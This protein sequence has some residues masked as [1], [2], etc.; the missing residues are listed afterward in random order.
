MEKKFNLVY[1]IW[2]GDD[3]VPNTKIIYGD[4]NNIKDPYYLFLHYVNDTT[5]QKGKF[6][7]IRHKLNQIS[8][9]DSEKYY[10]VINYGS[11]LIDL[12]YHENKDKRV[13]FDP[14][15]EEVKT[16]FRNNKNL[17]IIFINEHEP[18]D[19]EG[20]ELLHNY[21]KKN[22]LD[23]NRF[24]LI[25]NNSNL[26][27]HTKKFDSKINTYK[28]NFIPHS[29]T[30]VLLKI[31]GVDFIEEKL[32]KFFMCFNKSPKKHR[33]ALL[34][35]MT[36]NNLLNQTNWSYVPTW[37]CKF[38]YHYVNDFFNK[39]E[40]SML[41]T[42]IDFLKNLH[43]KVSDYEKDKNYFNE[44]QEINRESFPL[45][46]HVPESLESYENSYFNIITES[47]FQN[48]F[49]IIHISEKSLKP[50]FYY[51][52]PLILATPHHI[53]KMKDLY[54]LD[55]FDD[56]INHDYDNIIDDRERLIGFIKE[57]IRINNL[58]NEFK[59]FYK[60]NKER[61]INNRKKIEN[62][63]KIVDKDYLF[64]ESLL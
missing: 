43:I 39:F 52:F 20:F 6:K 35:L 5:L 14:L 55:F 53:K 34:L 42:E 41:K 62:I 38:D 29:Y 26:D 17:N 37:D 31:G 44:Y 25:N 48:K 1:D 40:I 9:D 30:K 21:V 7:L 60:N 11:N 13:E 23:E 63:L 46:L 19:I 49:E 18:D 10:Y 4:R 27:S 64:F 36:K 33:F 58:K 16:A 3:L 28:L 45:W 12:F 56:V 47:S 51:Q 8:F 57:V 50:F 24:Y 32:G 15:S 59:L 61:F 2:E 54:D 22:N